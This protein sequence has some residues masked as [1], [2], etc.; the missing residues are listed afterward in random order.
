MYESGRWLW[1]QLRERDRECRITLAVADSNGS[2]EIKTHVRLYQ[3]GVKTDHVW[4]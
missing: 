1:K 3:T 2:N 4:K